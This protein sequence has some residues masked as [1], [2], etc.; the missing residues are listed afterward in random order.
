[1]TQVEFFHRSER[2]SAACGRVDPQ[3]VLSGRFGSRFGILLLYMAVVSSS[4]WGQKSRSPPHN[5]SEEIAESTRDK[6]SAYIPLDS[7]VYPVF[8]RLAALGYLPDSTA[9]VRPWTRFEGARLV[10]TAH[11]QYFEMDETAESLLAA[12]DL[13]FAPEAQ[14][15]SGRRKIQANVESVYTRFT[16][17]VGTPL[18]D[19]YHFSQTLVNDFG[20]P[21]GHGANA[22]SGPCGHGQSRSACVLLQRGIPARGCASDGNLQ[23]ERATGAGGRRYP[24]FWVESPLRRYKPSPPDRSLCFAQPAR[25]ATDF[26][27]AKSLVGTR[28]KHIAHLLHERGS[29][30]H[31]SSRPRHACIPARSAPMLGPT[32]L[33]IF[34]ARQGGVHF[35]RLGPN[36]I[37]YGTQNSALAPPPYLWGAHLTIKPTQ[38]LELGFAHTTIFA[39]YGRPL[40]FG[41]FLHSFSPLG[42]G[43]DVDPGKRVTEF[44]LNYHIPGY[45]RAIEVY[46]EGMAWDDPI[47]GKFV[48]RFAWD[49]GVYIT[50]LPKLHNFDARFE[51]VYTDLP[52]AYFTGYFYANPHYAQGYTNYSQILGSWVGRE[53]IGG[54]ASSTYWFSPQKK[55]G[56]FYRKMVSDVALLGGGSNSDYGVNGSCGSDK[57]LS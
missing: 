15:V 29:S 3:P 36:F 39:G 21:Y 10:A 26:W 24:A 45:R 19:G 1:M 46:S 51:A 8:D 11:E 47:E 23:R 37:P 4:G 53:G 9:M 27:T 34:I 6:A 55:A 2:N 43:Q 25:L 38:N 7:W 49:P 48:A 5:S 20:R 57:E 54:Q 42:N 31:A 28:Q 17:I 35:V 12:L 22:I 13:E 32:R 14:E 56:V 16:G 52:K 18:R 41:T 44:N 50:E 33:D 30:A 40:T